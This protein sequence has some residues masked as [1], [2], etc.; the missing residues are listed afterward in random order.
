MLVQLELIRYL[1]LAWQVG[2]DRRPI[3]LLERLR[4]ISGRRTALR[5]AA[6]LLLRKTLIAER[7]RARSS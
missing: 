3:R 1:P 5:L 2:R 4:A 7:L 6:L